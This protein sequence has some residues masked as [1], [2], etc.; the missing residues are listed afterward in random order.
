MT[1]LQ[2]KTDR[3]GGITVYLDGDVHGQLLPEEFAQQLAE[4]LE[5]WAQREMRG[6][7]LH[8]PSTAAHLIAPAVN[9]G[10][11]FHHAKSG[12]VMLTRWLPESESRLPAYPHHQIGVGGMVLDLEGRVLCI[13]ERA[14][15]TAGMRDFWK[16]PGGLVDQ[17]EDIC[18]AAVREVLEETGIKTVFECI[19]TVRETHSGPFQCTDL[20]AI[21]ILRLHDSYAGETPRPTPQEAEIAATEWRDLRE[22]LESKYYAKG[23]YGSLLKTAADVA[24][25]RRGGEMQIGVERTQMK[26]LA[27]KL[28]SMFYTGGEVLTRARL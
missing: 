13:Q 19:A 5:A 26:G 4:S 6:V 28:E 16:L 18:D 14:G 1:T 27:G 9:L 8:V 11:D 20:Y 23:L 25:R 24:L 7:W 15:V 3:F 2:G 22:F 10:F 12:Y 17:G 21:C